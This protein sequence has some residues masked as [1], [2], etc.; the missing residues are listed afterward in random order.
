M[1]RNFI[2]TKNEGNKEHPYNFRKY[3]KQYEGIKNLSYDLISELTIIISPPEL[4]EKNQSQ[5]PN[6]SSI[7]IVETT[8]TAYTVNSDGFSDCEIKDHLSVIQ[9]GSVHRIEY[10][11]EKNPQL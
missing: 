7:I 8:K 1:L 10:I 5:S 4:Q 11:E 6:A 9:Q 3:T 2:Y